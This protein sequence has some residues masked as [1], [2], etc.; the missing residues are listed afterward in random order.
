M[1]RTLLIVT[2]LLLSAALSGCIVVP[3]RGYYAGPHYYH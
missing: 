3:D 1:K 2:A